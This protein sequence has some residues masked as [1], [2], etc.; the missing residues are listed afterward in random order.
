MFSSVHLGVCMGAWMHGCMHLYCVCPRISHLHA[1]ELS[2]A[3]HQSVE[4]KLGLVLEAVA[5][6]VLGR[7]EDCTGKC[8]STYV[9]LIGM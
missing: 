3:V 5:E 6:G 2:A 7:E 1:K 9:S 8:M 4:E